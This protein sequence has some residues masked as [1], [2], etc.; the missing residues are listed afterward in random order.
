M[1]LSDATLRATAQQLI[2]AHAEASR[3]NEWTFFVD[4]LYAR[5]CIYTCEYA[6]VMEVTARGIDEIKATHYGRDMQ[7]GWEG[8]TFP[9][10]G[11]YVG[12]DNRLVTHWLNR[13]PG[14][15]PDGSHYQTPGISFITLDDD[16]RIA[17]QFDMFDLA[18][19]MHLCDELEDAGLLSPQLKESW[20]LPMKARL[21]AQLAR[22]R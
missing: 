18:H 21:E 22:H 9:Y 12:S 1:A 15:R 13:G 3:S 5:D 4:A 7:V 17:R 10:E 2:D 16:A 19:Q 6:G 11:V 8:W 20:V 14:Q